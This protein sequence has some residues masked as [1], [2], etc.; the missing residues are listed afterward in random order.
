MTAFTDHIDNYLFTNLRVR[1]MMIP[2]VENWQ[3]KFER[4]FGGN[5][6]GNKIPS[7]ILRVLIYFY[8][9]K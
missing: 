1:V 6:I 8:S 5:K 7:E 9:L 2:K 4:C 3:L